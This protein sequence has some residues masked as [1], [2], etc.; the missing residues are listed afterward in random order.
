MTNNSES[1]KIFRCNICNK[2][3]S[4]QSSL[5]NHTKKFHNNTFLILPQNTSELHQK[6]QYYLKIPQNYI[7][8]HMIII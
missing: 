8:Y 6:P 7:K 3:Y 2:N 4:S 5:C 1:I